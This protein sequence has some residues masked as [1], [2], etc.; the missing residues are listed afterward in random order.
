MP[1]MRQG[2]FLREAPARGNDFFLDDKRPTPQA[3]R[4]MTRVVLLRPPPSGQHCNDVAQQLTHFTVSSNNS[5]IT[6][7]ITIKL[8]PSAPV[9]GPSQSPTSLTCRSPS[10]LHLVRRPDQQ[11]RLASFRTCVVEHKPSRALVR[12]LFPKTG[13]VVV[14]GI[15]MFTALL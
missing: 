13:A 2:H 6:I 1:S 4:T 5:A 9:S 15:A 14:M 3:T 8:H 11:S 12:M 7:T 10:P